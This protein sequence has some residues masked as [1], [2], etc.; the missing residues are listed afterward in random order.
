MNPHHLEVEE[1]DYELSIRNITCITGVDNKKRAL[2]RR[3]KD[4]VDH[5]SEGPKVSHTEDIL[6]D[7][8]PKIECLQN[9]LGLAFKLNDSYKL[10]TLKSRLFHWLGRLARVSVETESYM[11]IYRAYQTSVN[12]FLSKINDSVVK[13]NPR[14]KVADPKMLLPLPTDNASG[15]QNILSS[16]RNDGGAESLERQGIPKLT[17]EEKRELDKAHKLIFDL[18]GKSKDLEECSLN[19]EN[20]S[21]SGRRSSFR[22]S[23]HEVAPLTTTSRVEVPERILSSE[24]EEEEVLYNFQTQNRDRYERIPRVQLPVQYLKKGLPVSRWTVKFS[25]DLKGLKLAEFLNQVDMVATAER[26]TDEELHRSA[27]YLFEGFAKTWYMAFRRNYNTWGE[28]VTGLKTQF[29]PHDYEYWQMK[30]IENRFQKSDE[31][32][33]V[34]LAAME[35]MFNELPYRTNERQKV[36]II[37]RNLLPAYQDRLALV[38]T[39]TLP[40]LQFACDRIEKSQYSAMRR[41]QQQPSFSHARPET[42]RISV[43]VHDLSTYRCFNC[44]NLGH[45]FNDCKMERRLFCF[46]CGKSN[47]STLN[48]PNC[49]SKN[50]ERGPC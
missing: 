6:S 49:K 38:D 27:F 22:D 29:L 30:D 2:R 44:K 10:N 8:G 3:F 18:T 11:E 23:T 31:S 4:E 40:Q 20:L 25:G 21:V 48:C 19:L 45:H 7:F 39:N 13:R 1:L 16:S 47:F 28:L 37:R 36:Q 46:R 32:F 5:P 42:E 17:E 50:L 9:E 15:R 14:R 33:G 12:D 26:C 43:P 24:S 35:L 41:A 34:F